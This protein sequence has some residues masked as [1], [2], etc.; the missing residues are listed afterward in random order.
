MQG[1]KKGCRGREYGVGSAR[2]L[3]HYF[4]PLGPGCPR[5]VEGLSAMYLRFW[6]VRGSTPTPQRS[7]LRYGGNTSCVELR[8]R[9]G[10]FVF[11][12]GTGLRLLGHSLRKEFGKRPI[13]ARVFVSHYHWDHIQGIPFF[14]PLYGRQNHFD[15]HSF[16]STETNV[17]QA[18]QD[19]MV[20]PYF[21]VDM[22]AMLAKRHF[23]E[24]GEEK[25]IYD[26]V[27]I[28]SKRLYHPQGC[29]GFRV[30]HNGK[31]IVYATDNEPGNS[32][33]D[34]NVRALAQ[35]ADVF[36]YDSQY[37]PH[38]YKTV[39]KNWGHSTWEEAV[40]IAREADVKK[41]VLFHHDPDHDDK[42]VDAILR[43]AR[44]KFRSAV[45]AK[46]GLTLKLK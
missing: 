41:L 39:K 10:I 21:P 42:A 16:K 18:L 29:M 4:G 46:E 3:C 11:D 26:G 34:Q 44:R 24:I 27:T 17:R 9:E 14:T 28:I 12:C 15:F 36:I 20:N 6:G 23:H 19:Q 31:V 45:A 33:G 35:G 30:E 2:S 5:A 22:R 25:R 32:K 7:N 40:S 1:V 13:K 38:E 43:A 37:T 8:T